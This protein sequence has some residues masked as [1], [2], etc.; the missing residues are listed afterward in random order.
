M[1]HTMYIH[2]EPSRIAALQ[3]I[4]SIQIIKPYELTIKEVKSVRTIEQNNKMWAMLGDIALQTNW[5]GQFLTKEEWKDIMS[6]GLKKQRAVPGI[7]GGF[8]ILG[9][10]TSKMSIREMIDLVD[11]MYAFG[12][13]P[14]HRVY[15]TEPTKAMKEWE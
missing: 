6:A 13:D 1:K 14:E 3:Y 15:W 9:T 11:L 10:H 12:A 4:R 7:D 5:Y 8:V 2:N